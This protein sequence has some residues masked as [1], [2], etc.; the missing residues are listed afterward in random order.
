[1]HALPELQVPT[2]DGTATAVP[3]GGRWP[4]A[5]GAGSGDGAGWSPGGTSQDAGARPALAPADLVRGVSVPA[6]A[7]RVVVEIAREVYPDRGED[8]AFRS[9][10]SSC[11]HENVRAVVALWTGR[12]TLDDIAPEH[13]LAFARTAA[14][15]RIPLGVLERTYWIGAGRL[16][17]AWVARVTEAEPSPADLGPLVGEPGRLLFAYV[18]RVLAVVVPAY[19]ATR[20]SMARRVDDL[21]RATLEELLQGDGPADPRWEATLGYR[22]GAQHLAVLV[23]PEGRV[24]REALV[25]RIAAAA[26]ATATVARDEDDGAW[27]V[28]LGRADGFGPDAVDALRTQLYAVEG[29]A[30]VGDPGAGVEGFRRSRAQALLARRVQ[31]VVA[32]ATGAPGPSWYADVRLEALLLADEAQ[33]RRYAREELGPLAGNDPHDVRVRRTLLV[34]L[35][36]GSQAAAAATLGV[37]E[38]TVRQ[39]VRRAEAALPTVLAHRRT[40]L[41][42]ALRLDAA[43]AGPAPAAAP[44]TASAPTPS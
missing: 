24:P 14:E 31:R 21:R 9:L 12:G 26:G 35:S 42:V 5:D 18:D 11:V 37:H 43:L 15:A 25:A 23:E 8:P 4:G 3:P 20:A 41:L 33:A 10:L 22:L 40:E 39:H 28:W 6:F 34:W 7:A 32:D 1:M 30:A 19:E 36:C 13:A 44:A 16:W 2:G 27:T 17:D 38:N 29:R